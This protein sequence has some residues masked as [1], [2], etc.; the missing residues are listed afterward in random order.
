[1]SLRSSLTA[2]FHRTI[3][4]ASQIAERSSRDRHNLDIAL[5]WALQRAA[6]AQSILFPVEYVELLRGCLEKAR[7]AIVEVKSDAGSA[8]DLATR[9]FTSMLEALRQVPPVEPATAEAIALVADSY[10]GNVEPIELSEWT[11]DVRSHFEISSS[12]GIKGRILTAV[13]RFM[14]S[15]QCLELGTAYGMSALFILEALKARAADARLT[16]LEGYRLLFSLSSP[17][18]AGRYGSKVA[19]RLGSTQEALPELMRSLGPLD[20]VFHDA[21]HS[22]EDYVRD[23][24]SVL[25]NLREGAVVLVDDIRW[26][27]GRFF[28][29]DPG[30]YPGWIELVRHPRVRRAAEINETMGALLLG[31][32]G[33]R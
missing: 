31:G 9:R 33:T 3:E 19:C 23:F 20:L 28:Q 13:V 5:Q 21:G 2:G 1:V 14:R 8:A 18:L 24:R 4:R 26:K 29:G 32:E 12:E 10:R 22:R 27:S 30:C 25:P 11:G 15:N 6:S 16:T 17:M 7:L